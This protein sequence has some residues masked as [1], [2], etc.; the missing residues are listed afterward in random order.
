MAQNVSIDEILAAVVDITPAVKNLQM[1]IHMANKT[2]LHPLD[3]ERLETA[4]QSLKR[5]GVRFD[6]QRLEALL[7]SVFLPNVSTQ[8]MTRLHQ[9]HLIK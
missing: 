1:F 9:E 4:I 3:E 7:T 6:A 8:V 2:L 5:L